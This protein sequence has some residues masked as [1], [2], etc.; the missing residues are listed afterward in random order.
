MKKLCLLLIVMAIAAGAISFG[1]APLAYAQEDAYYLVGEQSVTF[2]YVG[3]RG[4][5]SSFVLPK[6]YT[7]TFGESWE[8]EG[9]TYVDASYAGLNGYILASDMSKLTLSPTEVPLPR[10]IV[11]SNINVIFKQ[12]ADGKMDYEAYGNNTTLTFLGLYEDNGTSYYAVQKST[13]GNQLFYV[14]V[15]NAN[16]E[17]VERIVFPKTQQEEQQPV[18][19]PNQVINTGTESAVEGFTWARLFLVIGIIAP[20]VVILLFI[21]RP[22][23]RISRAYREL[24]DTEDD[25]LDEE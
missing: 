11:T 22:R 9:V 23:R 12:G 4:G 19:N 24:S 25:D 20:L 13:N 7:I 17:D 10:V 15:V 5:L 8:E 6:G 1:V 14:P 18:V 2:T 21:F 16:Q 3:R